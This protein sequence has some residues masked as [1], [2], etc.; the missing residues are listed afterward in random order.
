[1][2]DQEIALV[3]IKNVYFYKLYYNKINSYD[4]FQ[5]MRFAMIEMKLLIA[6][7]LSKYQLKKC[8]QTP[9]SK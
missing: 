3:K 4:D 2:L 6:K 9:V 7:I 8:S 5:G 1:M